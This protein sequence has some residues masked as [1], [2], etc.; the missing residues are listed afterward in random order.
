MAAL[1]GT[2]AIPAPLNSSQWRGTN[3]TNVLRN[4]LGDQSARIDGFTGTGLIT[5]RV[6]PITGLPFPAN[7]FRPNPQFSDIFYF[8]SGGSSNY[9]G[10]IIS[11]RRRFERGLTMGFG[12]TLSKSIDDMSVDPVGATSGG[13][14]GTTSSGTPT[15]V[16]N[17]KLDR[18]RSDFDNRHTFTANAI[19]ELPFGKG[20]RWGS[21]V[22]K[23]VDHV[24]GRWQIAGIFLYQSGEPF[25]LNSGSRTVH[26][27]HQSQAE[28]RG[29]MIQPRLQQLANI[30]GP[31]VWEVGSLITANTDPNFNCRNVLQGGAATSTYF[32][33]PGPGQTGSGRNIAQGPSFWNLDLGVRKQFLI[34]ERV[35]LNFYADFFNPLNHSNFENPRNASVGSPTITSSV[36]GQTCCVAASTPSSAT[37]IALGEPNRVIQFGF[38]IAF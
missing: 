7:Y 37:V 3:A 28:I 33:I 20:R 18:A 9:H 13:R 31:S 4:G 19:Y 25:T 32:C 2:G 34:T 24:I 12:Y 10:G 11:V 16:R 8:D 38:K 21:N 5:L 26:N 29:P 23:A 30:Q 17:F 36:F 1:F 15:D 6:N 27:T 35:K 14:L 22:H